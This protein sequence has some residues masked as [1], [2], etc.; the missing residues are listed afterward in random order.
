MARAAAE[1]LTFIPPYDD[2]Y[3]IAGQGTVGDE[4]LRQVGRSVGWGVGYGMWVTGRGAGCR[5]KCGALWGP[6]YCAR[7]G[8]VGCKLRDQGAGRVMGLAAYRGQAP[9]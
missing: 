8:G 6:R 2:P 9:N 5:V 7:R 1:G 4:I 3:T